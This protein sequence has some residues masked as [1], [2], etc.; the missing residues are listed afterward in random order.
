MFEYLLVTAHHDRECTSASSLVSTTYRSIKHTYAL[1]GQASSD[2]AGYHRGNSAHING[3]Q[4]FMS[5]LDDSTW[6]TKQYLLNLSRTWQH[7]DHHIAGSSDISRSN[8]RSCS[9]C[10]E[11]V[12]HLLMAMMYDKWKS[13]LE[14]VV[15]HG[16]PHDAQANETNGSWHSRYPR[17]G[18]LARTPCS[19]IRACNGTL[20]SRGN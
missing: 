4:A 14:Q 16:S 20:R 17:V 13:G 11:F 1:F 2:C 8:L 3:D 19:T 9:G 12:R 15:G 5:S 10:N 6:A 7:G 18:L